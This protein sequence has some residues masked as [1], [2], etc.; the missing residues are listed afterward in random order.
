VVDDLSRYQGDPK[1]VDSPTDATTRLSALTPEVNGWNLLTVNRP[2]PATW[3]GM[4]FTSLATTRLVPVLEFETAEGNWQP[5][6]TF[7]GHF[8]ALGT[9]G[10]QGGGNP[11]MNN[12]STNAANASFNNRSDAPNLSFFKPDPRT[13]R[14]RSGISFA[15]TYERTMVSVS[16]NGQYTD[17]GQSGAAP[18]NLGM[19]YRNRGP[20]SLADLDG[21]TRPG[22][23]YLDDTLG[24]PMRAGIDGAR[25]MILN[26]PFRSVG[27]LGYVFRDSPW[28][29][30]DFFSAESTDTA[31]LDL[32]SL[33]ETDL[34]AGRISANSPHPEV[35]AAV[36]RG[37]AVDAVTGTQLSNS[38][39]VEIAELIAD[40]SNA[41]TVRPIQNRSDLPSLLSPGSVTP[42]LPAIKTQREASV[43][44]LA[45]MLQT[46]TWNL[47][48]DVIAEAGRLKPNATS[49]NDFTVEGARRCWL[50]V[51]IDRFTGEVV[52]SRTEFVYE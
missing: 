2:V 37:A 28:K 18:R 20:Q 36:L 44:A 14:L 35:L 48:I 27:E 1:V 51:A 21:I 26:R 6:T 32:F 5:Y 29:T 33:E 7:A 8:T 43:R 25:P 11:F 9:T 4:K 31:L 45:P 3:N 46:R 50:H 42:N 23:G 24:N 52:D 39:A 15:P 38:A 17:Q 41:P 16:P 13:F 22:D 47:M 30:L 34:V 40:L 19:Q 49:L 12:S 10:I